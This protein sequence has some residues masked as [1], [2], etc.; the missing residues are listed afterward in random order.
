MFLTKQQGKGTGMKEDELATEERMGILSM[1][2]G[3]KKYVPIQA[4]GSMWQ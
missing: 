2:S 1:I 4:A 3:K